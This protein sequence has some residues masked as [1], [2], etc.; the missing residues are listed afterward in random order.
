MMRRGFSEDLMLA[1]VIENIPPKG[2][3]SELF[4]TIKRICA[5]TI[6]EIWT[7]RV[8][9]MRVPEVIP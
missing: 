1:V 9:H 7:M 2:L 5:D 3:T 6:V 8:D 4:V